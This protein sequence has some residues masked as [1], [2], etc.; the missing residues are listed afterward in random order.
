MKN[1]KIIFLF[2]ISIVATDSLMAQAWLTGAGQKW[3]DNYKEW[4]IYTDSLQG[5]LTFRWKLN[6]GTED[7]D[8]NF[9][10]TLSG[11][12]ESW[13]GTRSEWELRSTDGEIITMK[14]IWTNDFT[15]WRITNNDQSLKL[16]QKWNNDKN[17]WYIKDKTLGSMTLKT[18]W[19]DDFRDWEVTDDLSDKLSMHF[20]LAIMFVV[21]INSM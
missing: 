14:T 8:Y 15:E 1:A 19:N 2:F 7:W 21:I 20:R 10:D 4:E 18:S 5:E 16:Q 13:G 17:E 12:I 11:Q 9:G 6:N 3:D